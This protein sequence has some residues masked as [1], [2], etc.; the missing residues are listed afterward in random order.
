MQGR[1][2]ALLNSSL[3]FRGLVVAVTMTS[4]SFSCNFVIFVV[5]Q[6]LTYSPLN[7]NTLATETLK[8]ER[9]QGLTPFTLHPSRVSSRP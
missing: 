3:P 8:H 7:H 1:I 4:G 2:L 6:L 5:T 9:L